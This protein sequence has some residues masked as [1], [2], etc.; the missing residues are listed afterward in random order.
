MA[1]GPGMARLEGSGSSCQWPESSLKAATATLSTGRFVTQS[2]SAGC[3]SS[4]GWLQVWQQWH[5]GEVFVITD[6]DASHGKVWKGKAEP[7]AKLAQGRPLCF[8]CTNG[9][10]LV[11]NCCAFKLE[12][13]KHKKRPRLFCTVVEWKNTA[14]FLWHCLYFKMR[15]T[16]GLPKIILTGKNSLET[17][18][19][20]PV[21]GRGNWTF[22]SVPG[23]LQSN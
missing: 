14:T 17:K 2:P 7:K 6:W 1:A 22:L 4:E 13:L 20:V 9:I 11:Q 16:S 21:H 12:P 18:G 3:A 23:C 15:G 5:H 10:I 19:P 8:L